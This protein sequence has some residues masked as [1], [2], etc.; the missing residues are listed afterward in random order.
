VSSMPYLYDIAEGN[1]PN[2]APWSKLGHNGD[3]GTT[4]E[5]VW[6]VGGA[7]VFPAGAIQMQ[8]VSSSAND[9]G[10]P[11]GTGVRTVRISYLDASYVSKT[12]T[13][14]LNG[15]GAVNTTAT[16]IFRIQKFTVATVGGGRVAAGNILLQ[17]VGGGV[18]Y[19]RIDTG[20][21]QSRVGIFTVPT[22]KVLYVT[23]VTF[24]NGSL[25]GVRFT[26]RSNY[27]D[28]IGAGVGFCLPEMEIEMESGAFQRTMEMP[29]KFPATTTIRTSAKAD[30]AGGVVSVAMRGWLEDA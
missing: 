15:V 11:V 19:S 8:V 17:S 24:S 25:K 3:V 1:V 29:S 21:T 30:A 12:T 23:S 6:T 13:V 9:D 10:D 4:E 2:H 14:T 7:Y 20:Y 28:E 5:D 22:G 26:V 27:D 16:D 18:T